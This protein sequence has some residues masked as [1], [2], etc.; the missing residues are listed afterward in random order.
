M[1]DGLGLNTRMDTGMTRETKIGLLL[2][3]GVILLI[4]IIISDQLS[5]VQQDPADFTGFAAESQRSIDNSDAVP[6]AGSIP[7]ADYSP[8][9]QPAGG[10]SNSTPAHD[11]P[12]EFFRPDD[13]RP[14]GMQRQANQTETGSAAGQQPPT[15]FNVDNTQDQPIPQPRVVD[16]PTLTVGEDTTP[17]MPHEAQLTAVET[18]E[19]GRTSRSAQPPTVAMGPSVIQHKVAPG[20]SLSKIARRYYGEDN[21][22][23]AIALANPGKVGPEGQVN[24]GVVLN[25]P[26]REAA[27]IGRLVERVDVQTVRPVGVRDAAMPRTITVK[28]NDT[29]S[30]LAAKHLGS[31]GRW[32]ELLEANKDKLDSPEELKVGMKLRIPGTTGTPRVATAPTG[33][34]RPAPSNNG[35]TYTVKPGDNLTEIAEKTL[36]T[37]GRWRDIFEAN[38][39]K[40]DSAD[41][42]TVGQ[43]LRI[44]S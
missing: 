10:P 34:S 22:W 14:T 16:V 11:L 35:E 40:L 5:Q 13:F 32:D 43:T 28:P 29:L 44:P 24:S 6:A 18:I 33:G 3:L 12:H 27:E 31:A 21:Y 39:D 26:K 7:P 17:T 19:P 36:G 4:G 8:G 30:E 38:R 9:Y 42:L 37:G 2:G 20:E 41:R 15:A 23:R 1:D 25:I